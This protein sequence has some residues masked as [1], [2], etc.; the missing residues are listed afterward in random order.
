[1]SLGV[2][3]KKAEKV[4][5]PR[6]YWTAVPEGFISSCCGSF[7]SG[8]T[9]SEDCPICHEYI[10][11]DEIASGVKEAAG[12]GNGYQLDS[13]RYEP[14]EPFHDQPRV[15]CSNCR[16]E[17]LVRTSTPE[18]CPGCGRQMENYEEIRRRA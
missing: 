9:P 10:G 5:S 6:R 4:V 13:A 3:E 8:K 1:M 15:K 16:K 2:A 17:V 18:K 7:C 14:A 11:R 12:N